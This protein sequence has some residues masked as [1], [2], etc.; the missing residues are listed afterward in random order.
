MIVAKLSARLI[1]IV[2]GSALISEGVVLCLVFTDNEFRASFGLFS[3]AGAILLAV[4]YV[5]ENW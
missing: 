5:K 1:F 2:V 4:V 3:I